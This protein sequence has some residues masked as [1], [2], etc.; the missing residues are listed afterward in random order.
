MDW[1]NKIHRVMLFGHLHKDCI[2]S[3]LPRDIFSMFLKKMTGWDSYE[4]AFA[5]LTKTLPIRLEKEFAIPFLNKFD[6][7]S[8][9][10]HRRQLP[11]CL[12]NTPVMPD[13]LTL[14][15][16]HLEVHTK[17]LNN[18]T[19]MIYPLCWKSEKG[20]NFISCT[21][22]FGISLNTNNVATLN[23]IP[24]VQ[25]HDIVH[26]NICGCYP[27]SSEEFYSDEEYRCNK[28]SAKFEWPPKSTFQFYSPL[29]FEDILFDYIKNIRLYHQNVQLSSSSKPGKSSLRFP[30]ES[31][32]SL[33][34]L[35]SPL[36]WIQKTLFNLNTGS[37]LPLIPSKLFSEGC[38]DCRDDYTTTYNEYVYYPLYVRRLKTKFGE[39]FWPLCQRCWIRSWETCDRCGMALTNAP[40]Y[41]KSTA[42]A[43]VA[44][45]DHECDDCFAINKAIKKIQDKKRK[46][47]P[48]TNQEHVPSKK[49]KTEKEEK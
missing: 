25:S 36:N 6:V 4:T 5:Y 11:I 45:R 20:E 32:L 16:H 41:W 26:G 13:V 43:D 21:T 30:D 15:M 38:P 12:T 31:Q 39:N 42:M 3:T 1:N 14:S 19:E 34:V 9:L 33:D 23:I 49:V 27:S 18:K 37:N 24:K 7:K 8:F 28:T 44:L 10:R 47:H 46:E 40:I 2:L 17:E 35:G 22:G 29:D 48:I